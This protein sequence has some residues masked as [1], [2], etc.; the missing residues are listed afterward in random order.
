MVMALPAR[1]PNPVFPGAPPAVPSP[2]QVFGEHAAFVWRV[3][4]R[5]G[6]AEAD[7]EDVCQE[8][9][10]AVYRQLPSFEGRSKLSTWIYAIAR[11]HAARYRQRAHRRYEEP[12]AA[13][14]EPLDDE[15][16][17]RQLEQRRARQLLDRLL[18]SL[19]DDKREVFVLYEVEGLGMREVV[20]IV[21][22]P[23]QTGYSRLHAARTAVRAAARAMGAVP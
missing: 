19:D 17:D 6:V 22:C 18:D 21:G 20:E 15:G 11:N 4:R 12:M 10:S 7:V 16:P 5:L 2:E 1:S 3:L 8:V 14:P 23:L 9:F 13:P